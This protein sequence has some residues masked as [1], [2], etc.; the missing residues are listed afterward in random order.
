MKSIS[1]NLLIIISLASQ[2]FGQC[3]ALTFQEAEYQGISIQHLDST[4]KSAVHSDT[5]LAVFKTKQEE[6]MLQQAYIHF[7]QDLGK[8]LSANDFK[9]DKTTRCFN[10]VYFDIDGRIDYFLFNFL[11]KTAEEKPSAEK[12]REFQRL[13]NLFMK[14]YKFALSAK[15]KFAQCSPVTYKPQ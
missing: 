2:S 5:S 14:D 15:V 4:Y 6:V 13:M 7:L 12:Q 11:G 8:F 9:W 3:L 10:R 1:I